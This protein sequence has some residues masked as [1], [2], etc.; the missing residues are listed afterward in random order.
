MTRKKRTF[1]SFDWALKHLL[2]EKA[3]RI[4][5]HRYSDIVSIVYEE[6]GTDVFNKSIGGA[7]AGG[8]LF[9]GVGAIVGGST[10]KAK[11]IKRSQRCP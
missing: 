7:V 2:R 1:I 5:V 9:G 8:I 6:N 10:A 3:N 4:F 11:Q